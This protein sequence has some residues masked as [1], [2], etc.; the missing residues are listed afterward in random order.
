MRRRGCGTVPRTRGGV[1]G[2]FRPD[3]SVGA[4]G[5]AESIGTCNGSGPT[6][7]SG[8]YDGH[9]PAPLPPTMGIQ[10]ASCPGA[11]WGFGSRFESRLSKLT[12]LCYIIFNIWNYFVLHES[13]PPP[14]STEPSGFRRDPSKL[15][16]SHPSPVLRSLNLHEGENKEVLQGCQSRQ[17]LGNYFKISWWQE[18]GIPASLLT[19]NK[20]LD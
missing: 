15:A 8:S 7:F 17:R 16:P 18:P 6:L 14:K 10:K 9:S 5:R 11:A 12:L 3:F 4:C 13:P 2:S 19:L 1:V 20:R